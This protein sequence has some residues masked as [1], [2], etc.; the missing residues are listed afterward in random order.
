MSRT[1]NEI[2]KREYELQK[3]I[4]RRDAERNGEELTDTELRRRARNVRLTTKQRR[5]IEARVVKKHKRRVRITAILAALGISVGGVAIKRLTEGEKGRPIPTSQE[6]IPEEQISEP[7]SEKEASS[8]RDELKTTTYND[9]LSKVAQEYNLEYGENV[10]ANNISYVKSKPQFLA[11]DENGNYI[12]DY[13][14]NRKYPEYVV[15]GSG[16]DKGTADI[17]ANYVFIDNTSDRIIGAI[18]KVNDKVYNIKTTAV[19]TYDGK[20]YTGEYYTT[21]TGALALKEAN[22][23]NGIK[24]KE[25]EEMYEAIEIYNDGQNQSIDSE[26]VQEEER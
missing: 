15:Q 3:R 21:K 4:A 8:F 19:K 12:S 11:I 16:F 24:D 25:K 20:E 23:L 6:E 22:V 14:E 9:V 17:G 13:K 5:K 2:R 26:K 18:G 7:E 10:S 1:T